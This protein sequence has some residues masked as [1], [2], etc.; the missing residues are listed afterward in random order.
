MCGRVIQSSSPLR[1][2]IVDGLDAKDDRLNGYRSR[3]N[4][5]PGQNLLVIADDKETDTPSLELMRWGLIPC[6]MKD[7]KGG[8]KPINAKAETVAKLPMFRTAYAKRRCIIPVDGFFEWQA[9]K[10]VN[11]KQPYAI[12]MKDGSPFGLA[13]IYDNWKDPETEEW[14][15]TFAIITL[16]ANKLLDQIHHRMP[17]I[18]E[19]D[20][21]ARWLGPDPDPHDLIISYPSERMKMWPISRRVNSPANDDEAILEPAIQATSDP[22]KWK[23]PSSA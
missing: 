10:D 21:Y 19:P 5:A 13:G 20:T 4:A 14:I 9:I 17:A 7:P 2:S 3:Y 11:A 12:A 1:L 6:W 15:R 8:R 22:L 18:L 16:P 23:L